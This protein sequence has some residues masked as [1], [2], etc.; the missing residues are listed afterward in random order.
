MGMGRIE[1]TGK[2]FGRL[3]VV[4]IS[5]RTPKSL[6]WKCVCSCGNVRANES[7]ALRKSVVLSCGC[8]HKEL[9]TKHGDNPNYSSKTKRAP[10]YRSWESARSR[11]FNP[12]NASYSNYGG[13]GIT[14]CD[15]W[16]SSYVNF[17]SDMGRKPSN[18]LTLDR[19]DTNGDYAPENCRWATLSTQ[20]LN[21][22][23]RTHYAGKL[24]KRMGVA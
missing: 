11:C 12:K 18:D 16:K 4:G 22:R 10:E 23:K 19:I 8:Y 17:I 13:R 15:R 2:V 9:M 3:T 20:A 6:Y 24:I 7:K 1:L 5:H 14:M 21:R